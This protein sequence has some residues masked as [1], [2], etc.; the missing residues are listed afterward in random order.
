MVSSSPPLVHGVVLLQVQ[1][2][3][4]LVE[5]QNNP[6]SPFLQPLHIPLN[7]STIAWCMNHCSQCRIIRKLVEGMLYP[8]VQVF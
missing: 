5:L 7:G 2:L 8:I 4:L 6:V 3:T 1:D